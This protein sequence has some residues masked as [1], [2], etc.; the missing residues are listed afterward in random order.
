[1]T[2]EMQVCGEE[3]DQALRARRIKFQSHLKCSEILVFM[4]YKEFDTLICTVY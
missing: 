3:T 1:M 4:N 2:N